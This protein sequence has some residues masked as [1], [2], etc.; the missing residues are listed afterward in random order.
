MPEISESNKSLCPVVMMGAIGSGHGKTI[1]VAGLARMFTKQGL[2]V[3][4]FKVGPDFLDPMIHALATGRPTYN[5]D[6]FMCGVDECTRQLHYA[7]R[8]NDLVLIESVLGLFDGTPC[9]ADLAAAL[10]VPVILT[11]SAKGLGQTCGA[12][13]KGMCTY[14]A[15]IKITGFIAN[16]V[17]TASHEKLIRS[18]L[19]EDIPF[20]AAIPDD[21]TLHLPERH[22]GLLQP[23]EIN[24]LDQQLDTIAEKFAHW[25]LQAVLTEHKPFQTI[26]HSQSITHSQSIEHMD[27][28]G[29]ARYA[30]LNALEGITIAV[31]RDQAF[32]FIYPANIDCLEQLGAQVVFFSP[33]A[34][35]AIPVCN[36]IWLPGGYPELH[37]ETLGV[38]HNTQKTLRNAIAV[39]IPIIAECG[40]MLFLLDALSTK[41]GTVHRMAGLLPGQAKMHQRFQNIGMHTMPWPEGE[42]RGHSFHHSSMDTAMR[43]IAHSTPRME[44]KSGEPLYQYES[45]RCSYFHAYFPSN[46]SAIAAFFSS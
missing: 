22:L 35:D 6:L 18:A 33:L 34:D 26:S 10:D 23:T 7:R 16:R 13:V 2:R 4:V 25:G 40:G 1:L 9:S 11:L 14:R 31:A 24:G 27:S 42:L 8:M 12:L 41:E 5:L 36:G 17:N 39:N 46:P 19:P 37:G 20:I 15:D 38:A 28:T 29:K 21:S 43:T 30:G 3:Q 44:D 32:S 45:V